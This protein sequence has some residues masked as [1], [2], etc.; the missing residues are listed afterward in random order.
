M[1]TVILNWIKCIN[2]QDSSG[3]GD[4]EMYFKWE[5]NKSRIYDVDSGEKV[6]LGRVLGSASAGDRLKFSL[7]DSD[8]GTDSPNDRL[9]NKG[10]TDGRRDPTGNGFLRLDNPDDSGIYIFKEFGGTGEYRVKF[11]IV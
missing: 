3:D 8:E 11:T 2:E 4:D 6:N 9:F 5:G 1:A 7:W 10:T